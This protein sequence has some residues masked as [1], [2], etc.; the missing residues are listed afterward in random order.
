MTKHFE[1]IAD[2]I[3][4]LSAADDAS[5]REVAAP[6]GVSLPYFQ[7]V[8]KRYVGVS[9]HQ[10]RA[11][12]TLADVKQRLL[13]GE[14]ILPASWDA[15]LSGSGRTHDL[16]ITFEAMTPKQFQ[17]HGSGASIH[18]GRADSPFGAVLLA[19]TARGICALHFL[20]D[21]NQTQQRQQLEHRLQN[22]WHAARFVA[23]DNRA[24]QLVETIFNNNDNAKQNTPLHVRGTNF[25]IN[26]WRALL[27]IPAGSVTSYAALS[28]ALTNTPRA[29]RA[30]AAA[31]GANPIA[32]LIP[33][34]RLLASNGQLQ[35]Y[36]WGMPRKRQLLAAEFAFDC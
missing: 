8:F 10:F 34:H 23:D 26:V 7:R 6:H 24:T 35:G 11:C 4:R 30:V 17:T 1:H 15:G 31:A 5:E 20:Q 3:E 25:Q 22:R 32:L 13:A 28:Q 29:A 9:P 12:L 33:C 19:T 21:K 2:C 27:S 16:F 36:A 18:I 14:R